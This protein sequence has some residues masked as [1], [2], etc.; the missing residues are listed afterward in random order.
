MVEDI[1]IRLITCNDK[2]E[3]MLGD[4]SNNYVDSPNKYKN[5]SGSKNTKIEIKKP[6]DKFMK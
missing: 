1:L 2:N 6:D 4:N 3:Q 5:N